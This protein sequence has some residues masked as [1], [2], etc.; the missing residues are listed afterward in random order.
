MR[1]A[2]SMRSRPKV[3][4]PRL[5]LSGPSGRIVAPR[6]EE[7]DECWLS[8]TPLTEYQW[9][10]RYQ[11]IVDG[12][13]TYHTIT[14]EPTRMDPNT[15]DLGGLPVNILYTDVLVPGVDAQM[16]SS[17][18]INPLTALHSPTAGV[19]FQLPLTRAPHDQT[20]WYSPN[21]HEYSQH[22]AD[23][24]RSVQLFAVKSWDPTDGVKFTIS[25]WLTGPQPGVQR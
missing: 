5:A 15:S 22:G 13:T 9:R 20:K 12:N 10:L 23:A 21:V 19:I 6:H 2:M 16:S 17:V 1:V 3:A 11:I 25:L 14:V 7:V 8:S 24:M 4:K 18:D